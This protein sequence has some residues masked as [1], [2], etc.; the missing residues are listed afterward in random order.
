MVRPL[1]EVLECIEEAA[2]T[3]G[4]GG[5]VL[6][7]GQNHLIYTPTGHL[8]VVHTSALLDWAAAIKAHLENCPS[9]KDR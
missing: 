7:Q 6:P 8:S 4:G 9:V 3:E 2:K 1:D 5:W